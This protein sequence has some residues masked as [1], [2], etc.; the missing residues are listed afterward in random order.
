MPA[1]TDWAARSPSII[2]VGVRRVLV[3]GVSGLV[4]T[5]LRRTTPEGIEVFGLVHRHRVTG[6]AVVTADLRDAK[7][8]W[9][10]I[11][12]VHPEV[13]IHAAYAND[14]ASIVDATHHVAAA[15]RRLG[16]AVVFVSS[17]AVFGGD[18]TQ[19]VEN[20]EPD[21]ITAYGRWK[22]EAER[23]V[24]DFDRRSAVVR[25]PLVVSLEPADAAVAS[26]CEGAAIGKP[27]T[28]F[29]DE[30]RQPAMAAQIAR[31]IWRIA[32]LGEAERGGVWHLPGAQ[33]MSRYDIAQRVVGALDFDDTCVNAE[34]TPGDIVR[35]RVLHLSGD[36][37]RRFIGW[38]PR[39]ILEHTRDSVDRTRC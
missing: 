15:A 25:L 8:T 35:P 32:W 20:D 18:G 30:L 27:T 6:L 22:A 26:I 29:D 12:Q 14:A 13:I 37:A 38:Y 10:A 7:A 1:G 31:A 19:R 5:W 33:L 4:G 3:T 16:A 24:A 34:S 36:R 17:D 9:D 23:I 2:G 11:E 28:W 21:P 39:P